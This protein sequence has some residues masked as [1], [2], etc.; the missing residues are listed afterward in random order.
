MELIVKHSDGEMKVKIE[1]RGGEF[2]VQIGDQS[3]VILSAEAMSGVRS[4]LVA[5][6]QFE[7]AVRSLGE[8]RYEVTS[9]GGVET[10]QVQD[11]L[12]A[13][14]EAAHAGEEDGQR[15]RVDA[16]MPG[17]VTAVMVEEGAEVTAGQGI[18]VLEAMKMEN[19]IQAERD[20]VISK[21]HVEAGQAVEG[22][23]PLFELE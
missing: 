7:V 15:R 22:G 12:T 21:I 16:N 17:K 23:D 6:E 5:G 9:S 1:R 3:Y 2:N 11:P 14:A 19:E 4:L 13:L 8:D 18:V 20:G 10:V